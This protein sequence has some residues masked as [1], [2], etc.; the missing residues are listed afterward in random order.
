MKYKQHSHKKK[1]YTT[2]QKVLYHT[3][4]FL[5]SAGR[6]I[7]EGAKESYR[8]ATNPKVQR[9]F[10]ET[11][12]EIAKEVEPQVSIQKERYPS[13]EEIRELER[14]N[15]KLKMKRRPFREP[16]TG[17]VREQPTDNSLRLGFGGY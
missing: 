9:Y 10:K 11:R 13:R 15:K 6:A 5:G 8:V 4:K 2:T 12:S 16:F 14:I 3:G 1:K 17:V 7:K